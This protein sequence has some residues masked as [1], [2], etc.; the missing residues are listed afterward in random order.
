MKIERFICLSAL[1]I[2]ALLFKDSNHTTPDA[3]IQLSEERRND[4]KPFA[5]SCRSPLGV[6]DPQM[7]LDKDP[8]SSQYVGCVGP[9]RPRELIAPS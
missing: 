1:V 4:D 7:L 8:T 3:N 9:A 2:I 5:Q 6:I